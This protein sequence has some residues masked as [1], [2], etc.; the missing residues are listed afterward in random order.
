MTDQF[1]PTDSD[2][3]L[4]VSDM[5]GTLLNESSDL[6]EG[7][8]EVLEGLKDRGVT[9]VAASGRQYASLSG[10]FP[11]DDIGY[12]AEN[13]NFVVFGEEELFAAALDREVSRE[14]IRAYRSIEGRDVG[15]ILCSPHMAY[16]ELTDEAFVDEVAK[17]FPNLQV[18]PSLEDVD[19][20]F[21]KVSIYDANSSDDIYPYFAHLADDS[22]V[23]TSGPHWID[24]HSQ[25]VS[26]GT[27]LEILQERLGV[28]PEQTV[29]FGDYHNDLP[30]FPRS[31]HT[32]APVTAHEDIKAAANRIIPSNEDAGVIQVLSEFLEG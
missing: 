5:D 19:E 24:I 20:D 4:V 27:G 25:D 9:F 17:Y 14:A 2:I 3:R 6:P 11:S 12:I 29:V 10:L 7:I 31:E 23:V 13:G 30:M 22:E 26:K 1:F 28:G 18:V 21:A 16:T 15:M 32:F 8:E